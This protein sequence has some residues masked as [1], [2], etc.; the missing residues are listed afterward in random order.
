MLHGNEFLLTA[1]LFTYMLNI[2]LFCLCATDICLGP[3]TLKLF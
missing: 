1:F 2:S 3:D